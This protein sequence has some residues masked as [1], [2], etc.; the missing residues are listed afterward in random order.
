MKKKCR[1]K[2]KI[3]YVH[4]GQFQKV[5]KSDQSEFVNAIKKYCNHMIQSLGTIGTD[6]QYFFV[7]RD[8]VV[9]YTT[10]ITSVA[11][12]WIEGSLHT[13]PLI[14]SVVFLRLG[15]SNF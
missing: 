10:H 2:E 1:E 4:L 15:Y 9:G 14:I 6:K 12:V 11:Q 3:H 5:I 7:I 13:I 8:T